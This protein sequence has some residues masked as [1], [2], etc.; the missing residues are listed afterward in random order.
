M[1]TQSERPLRLFAVCQPSIKLVEDTFMR[2]AVVTQNVD[3]LVPLRAMLEEPGHSVVHATRVDCL[4]RLADRAPIDLV[5][6]DQQFPD[7]SGVE[8]LT[9]LRRDQPQTLTAMLMN[10]GAS[11]V[12]Q[13]ASDVGAVGLLMLPL[14][15]AAV[16]QFVERVEDVRERRFAAAAAPDPVVAAAPIEFHGM[17]GSATAMRATFRAIARVGATDATV[18]VTGESGTGKELVAHALHEESARR[19]KPFVALNCSALPSELV[20]SELFGHVRGAFTGA[21]KDRA[22]LFEAANGGTLFLDEIGDLGLR[23]Q[24]K[25]LRALESGEIMRV[26]GTTTTKVN[27]RVIA[28]TNQPLDAMVAAGTFR[29]DLLYRLKVIPLVLPPLR[30][31]LED[32]PLLASHFLRGFA[33]HHALRLRSIDDEAM[34]LLM[35]HPWSG[36]VRELRNVLEHALVMAD[37]PQIRARDL[38]ASVAPKQALAPASVMIDDSLT[39]P[40]IEARKRALFAFDRAFLSQ[41]LARHGGSI[42]S[43]ARAVGLHRQSLQKLLSRREMRP[44][45]E[46]LTTTA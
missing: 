31:R 24:A 43:T 44:T 1:V 38:P 40:F 13:L 25:V 3:V 15:G 4:M 23:A 27:V 34:A 5:I 39:L 17:Y 20:E 16:N 22:G 14:D 35:R 46:V 45:A 7:G 11:Y 32:I 29:E 28:A 37:G 9:M 8:L 30:E 41:A 2:I 19:R 26:G 12:P 10:A 36:N 42:A 18:L 21:V 6:A 33:E